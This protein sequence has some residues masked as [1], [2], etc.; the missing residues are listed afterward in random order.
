[1]QNEIVINAEGG[2]TR[3]ALL[4]RSVFTELHIERDSDKNV[5]GNV[6]K[7]RVMRVLPG[8][9][10]AFV[11]IGLEKAAFL[12]VGDYFDNT[13]TN[14]GSANGDKAGRNGNGGSKGAPKGPRRGARGR[15][16]APP[17]IESVLREGQ[18]IVVQIAKEPIGTKGA[19]ITSNISIPGRHLVLTPWS[20]RVGVSRRIGSDK[21]RKRLREIVDRLKPKD[22][23]FII[24]T[25]GDGVRE[26]DLE[27]DIRYLTTVWTRIR[28]RNAER[29]APAVLHEEH[30]ISL[31]IIR[32]L[33][34]QDT[35]RIVI[36]GEEAFE[37]IKTFAEEFMAEPRP[38]IE[39]YEGFEPIFDH[40]E[41]ENQIHAN[42]ER[43][44]WLKSGGSLV[45]D[46]NEALTSIDVNTGR[47]VG[48]SDLEETVFKNN[49]EAVKE[50]VN[51]LRFRNIGGLIIIDL[52]DME[53]AEHRD[54]VYRALQEA[55]RSDKARTNI[56]KISELGLVEMTRKRTRESLV[57]TLC[58]P[59]PH[60]E[61]RGY[62][63][64]TE[65]VGYKVLREIRTD[66]P[67]FCGR[68][69]ALTVS[70][71]LAEQ[72]LGPLAPALR[73]LSEEL[74]RDI[75]VRAKPGM[76]QEQFE[77]I[78]LD[79][80]PSVEIPLEWLRDPK[81]VAAAES[82]RK[83]ETKRADGK[84]SDSKKSEPRERTNGRRSRRGSERSPDD[85]ADGEPQLEQGGLEADEAPSSDEPGVDGRRASSDEP[86]VAVPSSVTAAPEHEPSE[87]ARPTADD[88][89]A[90][91][92]PA[93]P[94]QAMEQIAT[95]TEARPQ[96][97]SGEDEVAESRAR[98][99]DRAREDG[100]GEGMEEKPP[101]APAKSEQA[102]IAESS[103]LAS[104]DSEEGT[105]GAETTPSKI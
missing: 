14:A 68:Q 12:Y 101:A 34:N 49:L 78:A 79:E 6:V 88:D 91:D 7:G 15:R 86:A 94:P 18:E 30:D 37:Q 55:I 39:R 72:L 8:M 61:G 75:E 13:G 4:E 81:E 45:I 73:G 44:V 84:K 67:R 29:P 2:E 93:P 60:C 23:G 24:R 85:E 11:D 46:Q 89:A 53:K 96:A 83:S 69:V 43:K 105:A 95:S 77:I 90:A 70:P 5:A 33:A 92:E 32:D 102:A 104:A 98:G 51:Q 50:V 42:L 20:K 28:Q 82:S 76:H 9:Q 35:K 48:K 66:L 47:F 1:M 21:E 57:Q 65:T 19:R 54:K 56:L 103:P 58:E 80:G 99:L 63:L 71:H 87:P 26:A 16:P 25:A 10:A 27:A 3:V 17:P 59:C 64:S 38:E 97:L 52:I 22:I 40:F 31:R 41:L 62:I 74:G 36:D 100:S